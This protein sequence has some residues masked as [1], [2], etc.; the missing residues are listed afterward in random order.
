MKVY[1]QLHYSLQDISYN[2]DWRSR[3]GCD[4]QNALDGPGAT[5]GGVQRRR[6]DALSVRGCRDKGLRIRMVLDA[7]SVVRSPQGCRDE[8]GRSSAS[9]D[10][11]SVVRSPRGAESNI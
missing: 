2:E 10:V 3:Q 6:L 11:L 7:L 5:W 4:K 9:L 1:Y 8:G